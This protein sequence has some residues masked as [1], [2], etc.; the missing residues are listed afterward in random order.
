MIENAKNPHRLIVSIY[1]SYE[2]NSQFDV[3]QAQKVSELIKQ[4]HEINILIYIQFG[5]LNKDISNYDARKKI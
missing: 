2:P 3:Q 4:Y 1:H 5:A